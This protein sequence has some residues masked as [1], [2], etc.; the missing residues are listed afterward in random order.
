MELLKAYSFPGNIRELRNVLERARLFVGDAEITAEVLPPAIRGV[1]SVA[2][3]G[4]RSSATTD[5]ARAL[6]T[7]TGTRSDLAGKLGLSERT[8]YR[9]LRSLKPPP[10]R[11]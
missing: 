5:I 4:A 11:G 1:R 9:R 6:A 3:T 2:R 7:F 8:L 10:E